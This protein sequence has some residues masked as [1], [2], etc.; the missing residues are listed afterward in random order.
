[1]RTFLIRIVFFIF[2]FGLRVMP[3][4]MQAWLACRMG[5]MIYS[6]SAARRRLILSNLRMAFGDEKPEAELE[7]IA[8]RSYQNIMMTAFEFVRFPLYSGADIVRMVDV[9]GEENMRDAVSRG[10][11]VIVVSAHFGSWE[12]LAA[13]IHTLG[14]PMTA[15]GRPQNDSMINDFIVKMRT[16]KGTRHIPRGVPMFDHIT[17]LLG[18]NEL[19]GLVSDQ[20][21][22]P[23]GIFVDFFGHPAA[24][25]KGPGLFAVTRGSA[26]VPVF[27]V[28]TAYQKHTAYICP[29]VEIEP[30]G[31]AGRDL[32]AYTQAFTI[33]IE[34]FVRRHPDHWFWV[35]KRWKTPPPGAD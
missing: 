13:R 24:T 25:F 15:V 27:I 20:N 14:F 35:H 21:A 8:R 32:V 6:S 28:R 16:S 11:G 30:S 19:V 9:E 10:K 5:N 33:V 12:L 17:K 4:A 7:D 1:M 22:G 23:K 18:N 26:L 3:V 34:D 31:D 29:V 2:Y